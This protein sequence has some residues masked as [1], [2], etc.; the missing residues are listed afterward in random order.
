[1]VNHA[2]WWGLDDVVS[3]FSIHSELTAFNRFVT[4]SLNKVQST[5]ADSFIY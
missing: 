3:S 5:R 1:M 4:V 2:V